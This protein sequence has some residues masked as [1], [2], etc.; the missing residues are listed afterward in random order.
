MHGRMVRF[1]WVLAVAAG[2]AGCV[3]NRSKEEEEAAR[4]SVVCLLDGERLVI[5]YDFGMARMLMP[6][7]DRID[8]YQI[9]PSASGIRY[10]N[11]N[12]EL[13]GK[14]SDLTLI[15]INTATALA[16]AQCAPYTPA[17]H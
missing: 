13:R 2:L 17:P 3:G 16:L 8:L 5:R 10:S 11:G 1:A 9:P 6:N 14:G 12:L 7:G 15:D 4:N